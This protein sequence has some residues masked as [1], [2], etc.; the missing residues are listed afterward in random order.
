MENQWMKWSYEE[1]RCVEKSAA[2]QNEIWFNIQEASGA[3][4]ARVLLV[5]P[6][7][8]GSATAEIRPSGQVMDWQCCR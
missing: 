7:G 4:V 3:S 2:E 5:S 6:S 8:N 1:Q